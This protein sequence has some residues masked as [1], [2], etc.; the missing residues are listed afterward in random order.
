M[1]NCPH[2]SCNTFVAQPMKTWQ[3]HGAPDRSGMLMEMDVGLYRCPNCGHRFKV[4]LAKRKVSAKGGVSPQQGYP[5]YQ[6][7]ASPPP[8]IYNYP[9]PQSQYPYQPMYNAPPPQPAYTSPCPFCGNANPQDFV[10]CGKCGNRLRD[11]Q[12]QIY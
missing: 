12:T 1:P 4:V 5:P 6:P 8:P 7:Y 2:G 9:P 10:F 3:M 11:E